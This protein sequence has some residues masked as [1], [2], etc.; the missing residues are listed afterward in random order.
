MR[1][2]ILSDIH[3][4][5][6]ALEAVLEDFKDNKIDNVIL[7][8]DIFGYYPWA[9]D[10]FQKLKPYLENAICIL[11]NHDELLLL[12]SPPEPEPSYWAAAKQNKEELLH[13]NNE[14][15]KWLEG[16]T[17]SKEVSL[18][19]RT[20]KLYHGSPDDP[21]KGRYYPDN[22]T[23]F[24]W[25]PSKNEVILMGHTH[26][27][28]L[29]KTSENGIIFNPG[30]VGQPRDGNPMPAWGIWDTDT[31]EF[32]FKRSCYDNLGTMHKLAKMHWDERAI[33]ALNKVGK[34]ILRY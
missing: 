22:E 8:G 27:P 30:S 25:F 11:G 3:S 34:G 4:N 32:I 2:A 21:E 26:Y 5:V 20:I 1:I 6:F 7:L 9:A 10:T 15:L 17:L 24:D 33:M 18:S 12:D 29:R 23:L 19:N 28:L 14:A 31:L 16:L 13:N